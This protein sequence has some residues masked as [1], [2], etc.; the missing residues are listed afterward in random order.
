VIAAL[1]VIVNVTVDLV[2]AR[3]DP[4]VHLT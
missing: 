2:Y 3:I 4:R 1:F